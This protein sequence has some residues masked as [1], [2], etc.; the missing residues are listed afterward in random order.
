MHGISTGINSM[1]MQD[2]Q[3]GAPPDA[4]GRQEQPGKEEHSTS[5][6]KLTLNPGVF[7]GKEVTII[8]MVH[9][10][11][12]FPDYT[13]Y[14]FRFMINCCAA[15]AAPLGVMKGYEE[16]REYVP[17]SWVEVKGVFAW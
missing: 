3:L 17:G 9:L 5:L 16:E 10:D 14:C 7:I 13:F 11:E 1:Q 6:R 4:I 15:D 8:G 2:G 12:R